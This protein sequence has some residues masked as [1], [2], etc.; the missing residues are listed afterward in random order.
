MFSVD[1][2]SD[3]GES[4][5]A[6]KVGCDEDI[7]KYIS[8]ANIAC[9]WHGGDPVVIEK[10]VKLAKKNN[11]AVGAHP[12]YPDLLGFGRRRMILSSDELKAYTKYQL[13]AFWAFAKCSDL[14][15]THIKPHGA[16]YNDA[17]SDYSIARAIAEATFEINPSIAFMALAN[18]QMVKA[19]NDVGLRVI[20]E[21]FA[22]RAYEDDGSLM[23]RSKEGSVIHDTDICIQRIMKMLR[24]GTVFSA[25]GKIISV[26]P[27]S[28]CV[29]G[30]NPSALLFVQ[31]IAENLRLEGIGIAPCK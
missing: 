30:D 7:L 25:S 18:S 8:S 27:D 29:H 21:V 22:D 20:S 15:V 31:K 3:L 19:A 4:Y 16:M 1:L 10:T 26:N 12:S 6:F 28:I 9:G 5:G 17:A 11:V 14:D 24:E 13:G 2:N 23:A